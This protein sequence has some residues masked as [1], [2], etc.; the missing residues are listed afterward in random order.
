MA[1]LGNGGGTAPPY[2]VTWTNATQF[3]YR[4]VSA[5]AVAIWAA[6]LTT[7]A[8]VTANQA[9]LEFHIRHHVCIVGA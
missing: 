5:S 9:V 8:T 3:D 2:T 1:I 6:S 4:Y 7:S